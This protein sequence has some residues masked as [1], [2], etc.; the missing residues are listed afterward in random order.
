MKTFVNKKYTS[1]K[2]PGTCCNSWI[3]LSVVSCPVFFLDH[4]KC[5]EYLWNIKYKDFNLQKY[6]SFK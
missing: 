6:F 3:I 2:R 1:L 5:S 4:F